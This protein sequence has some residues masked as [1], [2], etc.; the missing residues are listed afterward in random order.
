ME[1]VTSDLGP[2]EQV[3]FRWAEKMGILS[4]TGGGGQGAFEE[5]RQ[6]RLEGR[7]VQGDKAGGCLGNDLRG[8]GH[9]FFKPFALM[10]VHYYLH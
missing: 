2:E 1:K 3:G 7:V 6:G 4:I 5:V 9:S 10:M 8:L